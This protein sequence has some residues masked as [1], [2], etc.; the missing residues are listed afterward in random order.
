MEN[1]KISD[2]LPGMAANMHRTAQREAFWQVQSLNDKSGLYEAML[3]VISR[4]V[5]RNY[6][7]IR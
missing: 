3:E 6:I 1:P 5:L 4:F 7:S 2:V